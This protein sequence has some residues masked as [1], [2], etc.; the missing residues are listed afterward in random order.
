MFIEVVDVASETKTGSNGKSYNALTITYRSNGKVAEKKI[1]SFAAPE[2]YKWFSTANKGDSVDVV[3]VKNEKT[4]YWDWT[5]IG[6]GGGE[7]AQQSKPASAA[8]R[9]TGSNY[10]T[11]EER[12]IRQ[13]YIIRQ[14]SVS[15]AIAALAVGAKASP[16][17]DEIL[18]LAK[19]IEE[20]VF[21]Q[22]EELKV[23]INEM[24]DDIPY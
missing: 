12:A 9:V 4:G 14:S 8:T 15:S 7:V 16:K 11:K 23:G 20:Y 1:M 22:P 13:R 6:T 19:T 24:E 2:V 18:T 3:S 10:E 21:S 5:S 17:A